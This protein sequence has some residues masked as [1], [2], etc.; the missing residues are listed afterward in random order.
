MRLRNITLLPFVLGSACAVWACSAGDVSNIDNGSD[1]ENVGEVE[2]SIK[3]CL[4]GAM[5]GAYDY[6]TNT[7]PGCQCIAGEGNCK[8]NTQC[9]TGL[10]CGTYN[11]PQFGMPTGYRVCVATH[12]NNKVKDTALGET[13]VD[14]GGECGTICPAV[15]CPP[16]SNPNIGHCTQDCPC[17]SGEGDCNV[18]AECQTGLVCGKNQGTRYGLPSGYDA[19]LL[20]SCMN[21]VKDGAETGVDCGGTCGP[22]PPTAS[23]RGLGDLAGGTVFSEPNAVSNGGTVV[24][25]YSQSTN[26]PEAFRWTAAGGMVGLGD[27]AGGTFSSIAYGV[28]ADGSVVVGRGKAAT[29]NMGFRWTSGGGMVALGDLP[30]GGTQSEGWG[31]NAAD[32]TVVVGPSSSSN[33]GEAFTWVGGTMTGLGDLAGGTF[34]SKAYAVSSGGTI[35]V[36]RGQSANGA[37]AFRWTGGTMT[38]LGD[39]AGGNF[40]SIALG[41]S[42]NGGTVVGYG[43]TAAGTQAFRWTTSSGM[44]ALP[45]PAGTTQSFAQGASS[46]GSVVVGTATGASN[47]AFMWSSSTNT[48]TSIAS[49]L[50]GAGVSL[51]GWTLETAVAVSFDGKYVVGR[52]QHNGNTEAWLAQLP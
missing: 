23:F 5:N 26:G 14:C 35:V 12:C 51:T 13:Q 42:S 21:K 33:G 39:L 40:A 10:V 24:V 46:D 17:P 29:G 7:T 8:A 20:A 22:C 49:I 1:A 28:S 11:G 4:P 43:T 6:C 52:G 9:V 50:T 19:C 47:V 3:K 2:Q 27:L 37:E 41:V 34:N 15:S 25:G 16:N 48:S 18:D 36:G 45:L 31:V 44:V 38:G 30:G 32:G